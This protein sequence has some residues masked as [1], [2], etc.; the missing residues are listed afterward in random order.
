[1]LANELIIRQGSCKYK[2]KNS[3]LK[4]YTCI[5]HISE[6][7]YTIKAQALSTITITC[8]KTCDL[9]LIQL[10]A[11]PCSPIWTRTISNSSKNCRATIT[12]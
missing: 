6:Y 12:P 8:A 4:Q 7:V 10:M 9:H 2:A 5:N 3:Y 1:M 11:T